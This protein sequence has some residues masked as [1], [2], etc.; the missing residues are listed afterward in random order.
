MHVVAAGPLDL[1]LSGLDPWARAAPAAPADHAGLGVQV[2]LVAQAGQ[3]VQ[4]GPEAR[5]VLL[6]RA[7]RAPADRVVRD[8]LVRV[9]DDLSGKRSVSRRFAGLKPEA[10]SPHALVGAPGNWK[11]KHKMAERPLYASLFKRPFCALILR[12][13]RV[14][15]LFCTFRQVM[16]YSALSAELWPARSGEGA[17]RRMILR[18]QS[19]AS[20]DGVFR[21][22]AGT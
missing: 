19:R 7:R 1:V 17:I 20:D 10:G 8:A 15:A 13:R 14:Y 9:D 16:L 11:L 18:G 5:A 12:L 22:A 21:V 4:E 2:D 6:G 3:A